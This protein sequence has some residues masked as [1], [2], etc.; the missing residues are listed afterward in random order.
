MHVTFHSPS[1]HPNILMSTRSYANREGDVIN[2]DEARRRLRPSQPSEPSSSFFSKYLN[3]FV[4]GGMFIYG[5]ACIAAFVLYV[6][7]HQS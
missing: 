5:L 1:A 2:L 4:W 6:G 7:N 3:A